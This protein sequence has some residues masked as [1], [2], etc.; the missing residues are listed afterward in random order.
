MID[1]RDLSIGNWVLTPEHGVGRVTRTGLITV[2]V[3]VRE[4]MVNLVDEALEGI[5][6]TMELMQQIGWTRVGEHSRKIIYYPPVA[7][8]YNE[9]V[10][11]NLTSYFKLDTINYFQHPLRYLHELQQRY[12]WDLEGKHLEVKL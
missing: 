4:K 5:P 7:G 11:F 12:R 3:C 8:I 2:E 1:I 10:I 6:L 9:P